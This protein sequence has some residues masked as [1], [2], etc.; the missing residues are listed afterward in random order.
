MQAFSVADVPLELSTLQASDGR[1]I[2]VLSNYD[3]KTTATLW[4]NLA[5][6]AALAPDAS[7]P[8]A[9]ITKTLT[10]SPDGA[11]VVGDGAVA[12]VKAGTVTCTGGGDGQKV[13]TWW[14]V[15]DD[16]TAYGQTADANDTLVIGT[17][18]GG[19]GAARVH[20]DGVAW[21]L[22]PAR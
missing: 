15:S 14:A 2:V 3:G 13:V 1:E 20:R 21:R 4:W 8:A 9:L 6:G 5:T 22:E 17:H 7:C 19:P 10:A 18:W 11:Y 16:G 12:D